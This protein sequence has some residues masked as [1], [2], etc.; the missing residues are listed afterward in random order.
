MTWR[1]KPG[2]ILA[3]VDEVLRVDG[4]SRQIAARRRGR[5]K[6][7][8]RRDWRGAEPNLDVASA[9]RDPD[10]FDDPATVDLDRDQAGQLPVGAGIRFCIGAS[11]ARLQLRIAIEELC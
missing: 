11:L 7:A 9:D 4:R 1:S 6:S 10:E 8:A 2:L 5:S 3:A